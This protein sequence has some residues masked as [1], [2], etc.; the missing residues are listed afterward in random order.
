MKIKNCKNCN[1]KISQGTLMGC[2]E[3]GEEMC[4]SCAEKTMRICPKCYSNLEFKG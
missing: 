3:C 2:P 4:L 1:K